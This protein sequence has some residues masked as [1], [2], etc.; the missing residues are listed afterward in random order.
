[1]WT[2][3][4][5]QGMAEQQSRRHWDPGWP[6]GAASTAYSQP[7]HQLRLE[8]MWTGNKPSLF[9]TEF[10][11]HSFKR[12]LSKHPN[13]CPKK[14][15]TPLEGFHGQG[16]KRRGMRARNNE[17]RDW[18]DDARGGWMGSWGLVN[19]RRFSLYLVR[20]WELSNFL[21]IIIQILSLK[22]TM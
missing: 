17:S 7:V 16:E 2:R 4:E 1:M 20:H 5:R 3:T 18:S 6:N 15:G 11:N 9:K 21:S 12:S 13:Q 10:F 14:Q 19:L 22:M 8:I